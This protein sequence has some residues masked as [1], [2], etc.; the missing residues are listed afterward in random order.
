MFNLYLK[1]LKFEIKMPLVLA[2]I[3]SN[4]IKKKIE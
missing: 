2:I 1:I 4:R 3:N